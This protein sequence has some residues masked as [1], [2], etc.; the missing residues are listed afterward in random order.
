M[1]FGVET[2]SRAIDLRTHN[3]TELG[4]ALDVA[5]EA[6]IIFEQTALDSVERKPDD[7][8][9]TNVDHDLGGFIEMKIG[10]A[11]PQHFVWHEESDHAD[12]PSQPNRWVI[13][14]LDG[15]RNFANKLAP[16]GISIA[17]FEGG[18]PKLGVVV[19][20]S[21][22][23]PTI[24]FA[25]QDEEAYSY[26]LNET[27][28]TPIKP[29]AKSNLFS[30]GRGSNIS[31]EQECVDILSILKSG[32]SFR[33]LGAT[34]VELAYLSEGK[35]AAHMNRRANLHDVAAGLVIARQAGAVLLGPDGHPLKTVKEGKQDMLIF[36]D[37]KI[38]ELY[39]RNPVSSML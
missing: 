14:P 18:V 2:A 21:S 12:D 31:P 17:Y 34:A 6:C 9:V 39:L 26:T 25:E 10:E 33:A 13:D 11:F 24:Y 4:A 19:D 5:E 35:I 29:S 37:Q 16:Y 27:S 32:L 3:H 38:A 36:A 28:H 23:E 20:L 22:K 8:F 30:Y 15:T 1:T 7:S